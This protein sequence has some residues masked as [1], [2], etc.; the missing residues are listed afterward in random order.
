MALAMGRAV[1]SLVCGT[2]P[3]VKV[4]LKV[5]LKVCHMNGTGNADVAEW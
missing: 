1:G 3:C 5:G 2:N 4:G